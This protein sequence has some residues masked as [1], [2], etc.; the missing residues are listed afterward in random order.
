[1]TDK[2]AA[3]AGAIRAVLIAVVTLVGAFWPNV[4][5]PA[6]QAAVIQLGGAIIAVS[7]LVT[8]AY[9]VPNTV[10]KVPSSD[11]PPSAIQ[12]PPTAP[13]AP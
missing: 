3:L 9:T 5:T 6:Q 11:A 12:Q 13:P 7:L 10:P 2:P 8:F 1:M 4:F